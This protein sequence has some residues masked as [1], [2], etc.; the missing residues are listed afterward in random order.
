MSFIDQ[1]F[2]QVHSFRT[3]KFKVTNLRRIY[4]FSHETH[5]PEN[6]SLLSDE[7]MLVLAE[8]HRDK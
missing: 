6:G 1:N 2:L 5:S 4:P 3:T 8:H 7:A